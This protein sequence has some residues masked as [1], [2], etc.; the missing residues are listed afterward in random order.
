MQRATAY[1]NLLSA[2]ERT[3]IERAVLTNVFAVDKF[4]PE[5]VSRFLSNAA[6]ADVYLREF[7]ATATPAQAEFY[8]ARLTGREVEETGA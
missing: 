1:A 8:K 2:K 5:T 7:E 4:T 3:G 6:A